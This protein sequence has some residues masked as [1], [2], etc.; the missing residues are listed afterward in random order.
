MIMNGKLLHSCF[1]DGRLA[2]PVHTPR[3]HAVDV[4]RNRNE[5]NMGE[6]GD[7]LTAF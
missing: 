3:K 6:H 1:H 2:T 5:R 4:H 7:P